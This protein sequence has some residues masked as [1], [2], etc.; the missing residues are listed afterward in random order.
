MVERGKPASRGVTIGDRTY[1][2]DQHGFLDPPEQWSEAFAVGMARE[3]GIYTGLNEEHW[4]I[5]RY[6]RRRFR[7]DE[8]VPY[9]VTACM[10]NGVRIGRLR[11][12]FPSGYMRGACRLAGIDF[13]FLRSVNI[14]LTFENYSTLISQFKCSET[15]YLE[16]FEGWD[17]RF[18][19]YVASDWNLPQGLT[20]THRQ[21]IDYLR[22]YY[23]RQ[24]TVPTVFETCKEN[25][26]T[27]DAL[28]ALFPEGYRR[29]ACRSAGLPFF[30]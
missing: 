4:R 28:E 3:V 30:G 15:G 26:L 12:L 14:L 6:L 11:H 19:A 1:T 21:V 25:G 13:E 27:I 7:E 9:V 24:R 22:D 2:L 23:R 20:D 16:D 10:D 17:V 29:G 5:I 18:A 8:T